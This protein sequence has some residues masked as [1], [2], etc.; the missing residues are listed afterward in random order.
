MERPFFLEEIDER[1]VVHIALTRPDKHNAFNDEL[2]RELTSSL[3][4]YDDDERVRMLVLTAQGKS[5]SAGGDL[6]WM[7]AMAAKSEQE[8][9]AD[10]RALAGLMEALDAFSKPTMALVQ[11]PAIG[12]GL[13]LVSCCDIVVASESALFAL[14]ETRLGL[15]PAVI[16][17]YVLQAIGERAARRYTFTAERFSAQEAHRLGLVHVLTSW[18]DLRTRG[19]ELIQEV[20]KGGPTAQVEAKAHL[21]ALRTTAPGKEVSEDAAQRIA[22]LRASPEGQEGIAAFLEKRKASWRQDD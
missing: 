13:G 14:S 7:Q 5:F 2:I 9:L 22:R 15:I 6:N 12:G 21:R 10:A 19:E 17:P 16:Q 18:H 8:N 1:G 20:L 4:G 11:G 3:R